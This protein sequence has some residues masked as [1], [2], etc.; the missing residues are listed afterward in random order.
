MMHWR[1]VRAETVRDGTDAGPCGFGLLFPVL[2]SAARGQGRLAVAAPDPI[3]HTCRLA[4]DGRRAARALA[5]WARQ[6]EL[7]EPEFL[8]LWCLREAPID[9][10]DQITLAQQLALSPAQ[11]SVTVERLRAYDWIARHAR[12]GDRRRHL[13][14]LSAIGRTRLDAI[15]GQTLPLCI[16]T[17]DRLAAP[18]A[19][20]RGAAA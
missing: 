1:S 11:I 18:P 4:V 2:F 3:E 6:F 13:W 8:T 14:Q 19:N 16:E 20:T 12:P 17:P 9:G 15:L 5:D 10:V 7:S